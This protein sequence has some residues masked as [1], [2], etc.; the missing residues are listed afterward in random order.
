MKYFLAAVFAFFIGLMVFVYVGA[1]Q[2]NPV[3]LNEKGLPMDT[4]RG[5]AH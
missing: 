5:G 4:A 2:A 3:I 1:K